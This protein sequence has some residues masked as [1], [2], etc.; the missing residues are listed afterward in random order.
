MPLRAAVFS[1]SLHSSGHGGSLCATDS[2]PPAYQQTTNSGRAQRRFNFGPLSGQMLIPLYRFSLPWG[3]TAVGKER[4]WGFKT[5]HAGDGYGRARKKKK[6]GKGWT[7][8]PVSRIQGRDSLGTASAEQRPQ[9]GGDV[10]LRRSA[11]ETQP[12]PFSLQRPH[13]GQNSLRRGLAHN[14]MSP[15]IREEI[16]SLLLRWEADVRRHKQNIRL[17]A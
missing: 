7:L 6:G 12:L 9:N 11:D 1:L 2:L 8:K 16:L 10:A 15:Q 17:L 14:N 4:G 5:W 13:A 3:Q